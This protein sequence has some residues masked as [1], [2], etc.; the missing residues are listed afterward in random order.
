MQAFDF[1]G[2]KQGKSIDHKPEMDTSSELALRNLG[3]F[4][5]DFASTFLL[6][7]ELELVGKAVKKG[8]ISSDRRYYITLYMLFNF[9]FYCV[10]CLYC[11]YLRCY[12]VFI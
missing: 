7:E 2:A 4:S 9:L 12:G 10:F 3:D 5:D 11:N 1:K 6:D 8:D